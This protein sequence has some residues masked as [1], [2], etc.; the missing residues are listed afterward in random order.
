MMHNNIHYNIHI[1]M[2]FLK[3]VK[4]FI[5][6]WYLKNQFR[7]NNVCISVILDKTCGIVIVSNRF[8][9]CVAF[10]SCLL[11]VKDLI[12]FFRKNNIVT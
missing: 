10:P 6:F 1:Y 3:T 4:I 7:I 5:K 11:L 9:I 2:I 8:I 12:H